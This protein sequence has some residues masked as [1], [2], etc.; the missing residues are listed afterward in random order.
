VSVGDLKEGINQIGNDPEVSVKMAIITPSGQWLPKGLTFG[1][2]NG[3]ED[4]QKMVFTIFLSRLGS[5]WHLYLDDLAVAPKERRAAEAEVEA[6][7][8]GVKKR[9]GV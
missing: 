9:Y 5:E 8:V 1:P 2:M 3:P 7:P 4:F 6:A